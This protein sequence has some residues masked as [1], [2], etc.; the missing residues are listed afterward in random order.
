MKQLIAEIHRSSDGVLHCL[1]YC[2]DE[3]TKL[4]V[5][6]T[7][8]LLELIRESVPDDQVLE[9]LVAQ[10]AAGRYTSPNPSLPDWGVNDINIWLAPPMAQPGHLCVTNENTEYS[11]DEA[12]G[13]PQQ[14]TFEQFRAALSHWRQFQALV[15]RE[16]KENLLG[17]RVEAEFPT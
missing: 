8:T 13:Q 16:G 11:S 1:G 4:D 3:N 5:A 14:F 12:H 6:V 15:T 2:V 10:A 9:S 7:H 17:R